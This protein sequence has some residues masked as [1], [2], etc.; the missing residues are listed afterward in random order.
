MPFGSSQG[1]NHAHQ[2][3]FVALGANQAYGASS[4]LENLRAA[5]IRLQNTGISLVRA[6]RP[7]H[8][9]A[10]PDPSDPPF[11]NACI[12][13]STQLAPEV[14][15]ATL[16]EIEE[17]R[18]RVRTQRNAPRSLDLDLVDYRGAVIEPQYKGQLELPHPRVA[19][20]AFV[21]LP[22]QEIAPNWHHPGSGRSINDLLCA[23]SDQDIK[24][25]KP[26]DGVLCTAATGLKRGAG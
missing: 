5:I 3:I 21:L 12:E 24:A 8:T 13:I 1:S 11:T 6:S 14:L 18:G 17:E 10:W 23:L 2:G 7:W 20:R 9:P 16:H 26:A 15:M 19:E 25:C 22:L 4:P